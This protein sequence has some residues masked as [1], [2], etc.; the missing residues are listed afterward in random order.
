V[1]DERLSGVATAVDVYVSRG[2][3]GREWREASLFSRSSIEL[4]AA[5][6]AELLRRWASHRPTG[7]S[8][9]FAVRVD[10]F[11]FAHDPEQERP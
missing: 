8:R 7:R 6:P 9:A 4:T 5:E 1:V 2:D 10:P 11:E 3:L